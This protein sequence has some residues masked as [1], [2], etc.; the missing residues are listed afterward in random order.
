MDPHAEPHATG[1]VGVKAAAN[2]TLTRGSIIQPIAV[3]HAIVA[4][5]TM[6]NLAANAVRSSM[7]FIAFGDTDATP[8]APNVVVPRVVVDAV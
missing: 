1:A 8:D 7:V 4:E 5:T 3:I 6:A 2:F